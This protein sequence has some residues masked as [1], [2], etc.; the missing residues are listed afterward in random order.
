MNIDARLSFPG[1]P[2]TNTIVHSRSQ[3]FVLLP[4][5]IRIEWRVQARQ[6][7]FNHGNLQCKNN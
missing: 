6:S 1:C 4:Q 2:N 7:E 5:V 3:Y